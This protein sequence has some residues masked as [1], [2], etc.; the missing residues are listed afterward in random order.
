MA[1]GPPPAPPTL[2]G[3]EEVLRCCMRNVINFYLYAA[4]FRMIHCA[5]LG[6]GFF[7]VQNDTTCRSGS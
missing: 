2:L 7:G 4:I 3:T 6:P 5:D 1:L